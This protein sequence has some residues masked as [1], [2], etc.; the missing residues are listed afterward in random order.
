VKKL[1]SNSLPPDEI[2]KIN[3]EIMSGTKVDKTAA[4][5]FDTTS[6]SMNL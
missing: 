1:L 2:E 6:V 5:I 4:Q 3:A